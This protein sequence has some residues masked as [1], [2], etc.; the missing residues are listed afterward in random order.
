MFVGREGQSAAI[1]CLNSHSDLI[2]EG[3]VVTHMGGTVIAGSAIG[4]RLH[5]GG[6]GWRLG[7]HRVT[8]TRGVGLDSRAFLSSL[9]AM[10][11]R[12]VVDRPGEIAAEGWRSVSV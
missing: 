7:G 5:D 12:A 3:G 4:T 9:R 10:V 8:L 11:N 1:L 6:Q 2:G